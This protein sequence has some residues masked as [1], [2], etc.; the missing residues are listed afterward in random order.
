MYPAFV[1]N[2]L[3]AAP[4][5]G[6]TFISVTVVLLTINT[7]PAVAVGNLTPC[8]ALTDVTTLISFVNA[9]AS[10]CTVPAALTVALTLLM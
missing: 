10:P 3:M 9:V 6:Y 7:I 5:A 2:P 1:A 4:A 8:P